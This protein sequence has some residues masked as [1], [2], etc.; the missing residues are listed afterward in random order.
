[1]YVYEYMVTKAYIQHLLTL[2]AL[3]TQ[4]IHNYMLYILINTVFL[5][6]I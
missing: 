1:M 2:F 3:F 4:Q 6:K 5:L